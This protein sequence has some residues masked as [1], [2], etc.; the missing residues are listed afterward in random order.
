MGVNAALVAQV[1]GLQFGERE[2]P[3]SIPDA[4]RPPDCCPHLSTSSGVGS[5]ICRSLE[6]EKEPSCK[7]AA[8]SPL[9]GGIK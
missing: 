8:L 5:R 9:E 7:W 6:E 2:D 4:A 1:V 3:G